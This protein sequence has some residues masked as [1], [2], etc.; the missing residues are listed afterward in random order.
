MASPDRRGSDCG[1]AGDAALD[2]R[3]IE[4]LNN[5]PYTYGSRVA[6]GVKARKNLVLER[7]KALQMHGLV[8]S[9]ID[10]RGVKWFSGCA[11]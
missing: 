11:S 5:A 3:I 2:L 7:L 6:R 8:D 4:F 10:S 1:Q 9:V